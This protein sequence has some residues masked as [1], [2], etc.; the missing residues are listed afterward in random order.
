[1]VTVVTV[2]AF[3]SVHRCTQPPA[4][5]SSL[6]LADFPKRWAR[7]EILRLIIWYFQNYC[8]E[9]QTYGHCEKQ[10]RSLVVTTSVLHSRFP[11]PL[12]NHNDCDGDC[13][14]YVFPLD[15]IRTAARRDRASGKATLEEMARLLLIIVLL[16]DFLCPIQYNVL[17]RGEDFFTS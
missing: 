8:L 5:A 16:N 14:L 17:G 13:L 4:T 9:S 12:V 15:S 2:T 7:K 1:M 3:C 11:F 10:R 6:P